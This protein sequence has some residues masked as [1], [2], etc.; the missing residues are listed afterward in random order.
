MR[1]ARPLCAQAALWTFL[2]AC[3][4]ITSGELR[5]FDGQVLGKSSEGQVRPRSGDRE[6][7]Q[8]QVSFMLP[9]SPGAGAK[10]PAGHISRPGIKS[11]DKPSRLDYISTSRIA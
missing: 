6:G 2:S 7:P 10:S 3:M 1:T 11:Y 8:T 4:F 5:H 9:P